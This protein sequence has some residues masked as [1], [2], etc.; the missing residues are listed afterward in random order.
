M[1]G[2][3]ADLDAVL[4]RDVLDQRA[5]ADDLDQLL[6]GV[7]VLVQLPHVARLHLLLERYRNRVL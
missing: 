3:A 1:H 6:A 7:P 5:L 4:T 2:K